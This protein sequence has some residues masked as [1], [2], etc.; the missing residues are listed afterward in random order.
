MRVF[1]EEM[2]STFQR[3]LVSKGLLPE[4][5]ATCGQLFADASLDGVASHGLNRFPSFVKSM[6]SGHIVDP[7]S[8]PILVS[9][10]GAIE[11]WDGQQG[12]GL[13]NAEFCMRRAMALASEHGMGC[14]GLRNTN[15]WM[16]PANYGYLAASNGYAA[17][18]WTNTMANMP[19]WGGDKKTVGNNPLV[20]ACPNPDGE[21]VVLDMAM[22][23]YSFG[24]I[25][26]AARKGEQLEVTGGVDKNGEST[27]DPAKILDGGLAQPAGLWK[28]A[29]L[30]VMLDLL[31][32]ILSGGNATWQITIGSAK[33]GERA[34][35]QAFVVWD[36][37]ELGPD[38]AAPVSGILN[39]LRET[40]TSYPGERSLKHRANAL[41]SGIPVDE[42]RWREVTGMT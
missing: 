11:R 6:A 25:S 30:A 4:R 8:D 15:H 21:P 10:A 7:N 18:C 3:I 34:V 24:K 20:I 35:S 13:L 23:Q 40:G 27:T 41:R 5:A 42:Q 12:V 29:G 33:R 38:A 1:Y 17:M 31:A 28:G 16:R 26:D 14:I 2:R 19:G 37:S 9:G 39:S 22:S 32:T 36:L